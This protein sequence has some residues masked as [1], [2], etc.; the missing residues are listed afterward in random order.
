[1]KTGF[2]KDMQKTNSPMLLW[3]YTCERRAALIDLNANNP[4]QLQGQNPY[5]ENFVDMGDIS[6]LFQ[7]G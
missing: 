6:N 7:F 1:M 2:V 5:M 3:C 4:F